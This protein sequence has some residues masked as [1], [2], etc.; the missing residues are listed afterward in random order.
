MNT[1]RELRL[2]LVVAGFGLAVFAGLAIADGI[3]T[4]TPLTYSGVLQSSS[5]APVTTA[6]S[7]QL[8]LWDD[9]TANASGNQKCV[10]PTQSITPDPQGR[11]QIVLDQACLGAV[12]SNPDLWVQLQVGS[13]VLPRSKIGAVPFA[14]ESGRA[15]RTVLS[16]AGRATTQGGLY[17]GATAQVNGAFTAAGG[18]LT[19]YRAAKLLCEQ[20]CVSPT[21][22]HCSPSEIVVSH[23]LGL[24]PGTGWLS[25]AQSASFQAFVSRDCDGFSNGTNA[26]AGTIWFTQPSAPRI[27]SNACGASIAL[28]CCD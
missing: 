19:G 14:V 26:V 20:A 22:H 8:T 23:A 1:A 15:S 17:C 9:S 10:T 2:G 12:R 21:A 7:I 16:N 6:Q 18:T 4:V 3:P 13:I 28:L 25:S 27:D 24:S 11:F 5:G